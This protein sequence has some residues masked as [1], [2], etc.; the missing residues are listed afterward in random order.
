MAR[1]AE[2]APSARERDLVLAQPLTSGITEENFSERLA[3]WKKA[4]TYS[5]LEQHVLELRALHPATPSE[6]D[7][8]AEAAKFLLPYV[9]SRLALEDSRASAGDD[10]FVRH[11]IGRYRY[12]RNDCYTYMQKLINR[13]KR[14]DSEEGTVYDLARGIKYS[15]TNPIPN[16]PPAYLAVLRQDNDL[17]LSSQKLNLRE[18]ESGF[19]LQVGDM[20]KVDHSKTGHNHWYVVVEDKGELKLAS[21]GSESVDLVSI[22][23][24]TKF[25]RKS[26]EVRRFY[27]FTGYGQHFEVKMLQPPSGRKAHRKEGAFDVA[28]ASG[29][30]PEPVV[31]VKVV[32]T[33]SSP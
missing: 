23:Q 29:P 26:I 18:L 11:A 10:A 13:S 27:G 6:R 16:C 20:V 32:Q 31:P 17:Y 22:S 12:M 5:Q 7:F 15:S 25:V 33:K 21:R 24:A 9:V 8:A 4:A 14:Y 30:E 3:L 19:S 1:Q 28:L 2:I